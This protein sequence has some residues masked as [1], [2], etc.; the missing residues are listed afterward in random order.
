MPDV[1]AGENAAVRENGLMARR[2]SSWERIILLVLRFV[3]L[4]CVDRLMYLLLFVFV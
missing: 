2:A 1:R 3:N 4:V